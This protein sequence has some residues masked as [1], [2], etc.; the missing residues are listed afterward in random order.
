MADRKEIRQQQKQ[1]KQTWRSNAQAS[2]RKS[3][4]GPPAAPNPYRSIVQDNI[5]HGDALLSTGPLSRV[6]QRLSTQLFHVRVG[7]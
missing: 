4:T 2:Q 7:T 3:P 1:Q 5:S 6:T